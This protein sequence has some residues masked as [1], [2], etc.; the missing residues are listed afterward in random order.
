MQVTAE[1]RADV[2]QLRA[3]LAKAEARVKELEALSMLQEAQLMYR[4]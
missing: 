2:E 1:L 3:E 4:G